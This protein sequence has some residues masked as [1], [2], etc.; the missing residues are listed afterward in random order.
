MLNRNGDGR[1]KSVQVR[2]ECLFRNWLIVLDHRNPRPENAIKKQSINLTLLNSIPK[3]IQC[4]EKLWNL[5][6]KKSIKLLNF[7]FSVEGNGV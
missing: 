7:Y 2:V 5:C 1:V 3:S 6:T 4:N